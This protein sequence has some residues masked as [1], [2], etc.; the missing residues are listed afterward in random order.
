MSRGNVGEQYRDD[1]CT[2]H[3]GVECDSDKQW[4]Y[5]HKVRKPTVITVTLEERLRVA[6]MKLADA[7]SVGDKTK[8]K[9]Y[10]AQCRMIMGRMKKQLTQVISDTASST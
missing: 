7:I 8:V 6:Q 4:R 9:N 5:K 10:S 3:N 1:V 2:C